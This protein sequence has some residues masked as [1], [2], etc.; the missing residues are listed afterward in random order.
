MS[1]QL[2]E[3]IFLGAVAFLIISKFIS[4]LGTTD[5]DDPAK[6]SSGGSFFGEP[7]GMKDVT[8]SVTQ[9]RQDR[10]KAAVINLK[11][12]LKKSAKP[13]AEHMKAIYEAFPNFNVE[14]FLTGAKGAFSMIIVALHEKDLETIEEL[15]DKRYVDQVKE[16]SDIYGK[17]P[18][19]KMEASVVDTYS[20]G[21]SIFVKVRFKGSTSKMKSLKEEWVFTKNIQQTGPDWY[22][23]NIER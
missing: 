1:V 17:V 5:E 3:I 19:K 21:N 2:L 12:H 22:L 20:L 6:K 13:V 4:L 18:N 16:M 8:N 10:D 15:V 9:E 14:K 7:G 11:K 23:C